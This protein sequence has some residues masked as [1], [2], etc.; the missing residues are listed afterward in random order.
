MLDAALA[1]RSTYPSIYLSLARHV[2]HRRFLD[3]TIEF[4]NLHPD[5][6]VIGTDLSPIQ[7]DY[8]PVNC[9]FYMDDATHDWSFHQRFDYI[10]VRALTF[11][12]ADWDKFVDQAYNYLQP[13]GFIELQVCLFL[14]SQSASA[15]KLRC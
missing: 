10:H 3:W 12:I 5:V 4:A 9:V 2:S 15:C 7:P 6:Q 13:G 11:G 14:R 8:I 1:V